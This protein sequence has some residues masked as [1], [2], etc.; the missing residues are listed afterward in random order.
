MKRFT[1]AL[2]VDDVLAPCIELGCEAL[3][4]DPERITDWDL[5]KTDLTAGEKAAFMEI[6]CSP[7][8]VEAQ[9]PYPGAGMLIEALEGDGH[10]VLISSAVKPNSMSIR[11][12]MLMES[13]PMLDLKNIMLGARKELLNVDFLLDDSPYNYGHAR[14]FVLMKRHYNLKCKGFLSV[15]SYDEFLSMVR[16]AAAAPEDRMIHVGRIGHPGIICLVGP[17][18]SGKSFICDELERNPL[19][20]KVRALTDRTPRLGEVQGKEYLFVSHEEFQRAVDTG[21]LLESTIYAGHGYGIAKE[22]IEKIWEEGRIAI[23][24]VD[25][26][27]AKAIKA[28]YPDPTLTLFVRR[29]KEELLRCLIERDA[30]AAEKA[31]RILSL[32]NEYAN[33]SL[34]DWTISNNGSLGH[35]VEQV[36]RLV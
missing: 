5:N 9:K 26:N 16:Q 14:Y 15:G 17:S 35:A 33:E 25:I 30:P 1:I 4:I 2:D 22:E 13:F 23:K 24:P 29:D 28:T 12:K 20:K 3:G 34:C 36:L 31:K 8:F 27:G 32:D 21:Q 11:G 19:F 10:E 6:I 18:A 7:E